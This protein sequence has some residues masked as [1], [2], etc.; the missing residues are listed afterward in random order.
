[1]IAP[2]IYS[3]ISLDAY[4]GDP[5]DAPSLSSG[6]AHMLVSRSPRHAWQAHPKLNPNWRSSEDERFDIGTA[7]H[8]VLLEGAV[9]RLAIHDFQDWRT[10]AAKEARAISRM[11][12]KTPVLVH[13]AADIMAMVQEARAFLKESEIGNVLEHG[14]PEQT[15]LWQHGDTWCRC[16]PDWIGDD[17]VLSY[18][19]TG[20]AEPDG[21]INYV[22]MRSGYELQAAHELN[23]LAQS[24]IR[25]PSD[26]YYW[27]VQETD[28][29]YACMLAGL[30]PALLEHAN[31]K[32]AHAL[33]LWRECLKTGEWPGYG[34]RVHYAEPNNWQVA[35]WQERMSM[36]AMEDERE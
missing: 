36:E 34:N 14:K 23:G 24:G 10:K 9:D 29:P 15:I 17:L 21:W 3:D 2:G 18:K 31:E 27:L 7:A 19:T 30:T 26:R 35:Q 28:P 12:G 4:V 6:I 33:N 11:E 25:I 1:M 8:G 5:C 20:S 16:R 13:Q 32:M 22:A